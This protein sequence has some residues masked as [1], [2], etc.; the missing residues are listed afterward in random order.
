MTS[1]WRTLRTTVGCCVLGFSS[2]APLAGCVVGNDSD[3]PVLSVDLY[4]DTERYSDRTCESSDVATM[5]YRLLDARQNVVNEQQ[6]IGCR[7]GFDFTDAPLG[8]YVL[9]VTGYDADD[10]SA[11][12]A[13][14]DLYLDR[15]DRL[16]RCDVDRT[17]PW[18]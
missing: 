3:P 8:D 12:S 14:C 17:A 6:G 2:L 18:P 10:N 13:S 7:N 9:E 5:D 11:W 1:T 15:F 16:F 4:W